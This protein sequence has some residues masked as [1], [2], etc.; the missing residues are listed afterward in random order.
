M[1]YPIVDVVGPS[2]RVP[3]SQPATSPPL[4][5]PR[6]FGFPGGLILELRSGI[7]RRPGGVATRA[8][9]GVG[10]AQWLEWLFAHVSRRSATGKS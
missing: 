9:V 1:S 2:R 3:G 8:V 6:T 10:T 4:T 7:R 5:S